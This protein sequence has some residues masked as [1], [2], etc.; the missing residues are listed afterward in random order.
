M[1]EHNNFFGYYSEDKYSNPML[2]Y[3]KDYNSK[4]FVNFYLFTEKKSREQ[5]REGSYNF[6]RNEN[7]IFNKNNSSSFN[8]LTERGRKSQCSQKQIITDVINEDD[9]E[10][11]FFNFNALHGGD[12]N[13]EKTTLENK[14]KQLIFNNMNDDKNNI[15]EN[16]EIINNKNENEY[17]ENNFKVK[18]EKSN[19]KNNENLN[20]FDAYLN[21]NFSNNR[22]YL[23]KNEF[24]KNKNINNNQILMQPFNYNNNFNFNNN[25]YNIY[26]FNPMTPM[27]P[28]YQN[29]QLRDKGIYQNNFYNF[30]NNNLIQP[31]IQFNSINKEND[32]NKYGFVPKNYIH[33]DFYNNNNNKINK[34][35]ESNNI[36]NNKEPENNINSMNNG[37]IIG[38]NY[39]EYNE[40]ELGK[41]AHILLKDQEACRYLQ[42]KIKNNPDLANKIIF[43]EIKN[44]IKELS[45]DPFGNYFFQ[46]VVDILS[47]EN[48]N[49]FLDL[50]QKDFIDICNS[51]H[52][53]R[54]IQKLIDKISLIP[55]L[56]NKLIYNLCSND[57]GKIFKSPYGNHVIQKF[58]TTANLPE[59][60][61][62]IFN[63]TYNNFLDI[64]MT[65]H[66][67]CVIQK[68]VNI[69]DEKQRLNIYD[70]LL[71]DFD[72]IIKDQFGNYLIQYILI[73][74]AKNND[75]YNEILSL[76]KKMQEN[77][78]E[79]CKL[80]FPANV[81]EKCFENDNNIAGQDI[82]DNLLK[83]CRNNI[84][85]ILNNQYGIYVIQKAIKFCGG[86]YKMQIFEIIQEHENEINYDDNSNIHKIIESHNEL[87][88]ML[89]NYIGRNINNVREEDNDNRKMSRDFENNER[90]SFRGKYKRGYRKYS[91]RGN[92]QII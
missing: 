41:A 17:V 1:K 92:F 28:F 27:N 53:T 78:I 32:I 74:N 9:E 71:K 55:L 47:F 46:L 56:M 19:V 87:G 82:L 34:L 65:K 63:Y 68:C 83:N 37:T 21:Q 79:Y 25:I 86:K 66:G 3:Y 7:E 31:V 57:L 58:L 54:V 29:V 10:N 73:N 84:I 88:E 51:P 48:I 12:N 62:F 39:L 33:S 43:P 77:I 44:N 45:C 14:I 26:K 18:D 75:K 64:A 8:V 72:K 42:D 70:L 22:N 15:E 60:T 76:V 59:Y 36:K 52:G 61:N 89:S 38:K 2:T 67:V 30:Y 49:S 81:F 90:G 5:S 50:T 24:N 4:N 91:K 6:N 20:S 80:K 13:E 23:E 85:E 35:N 40:M 11:C 69:G 16:N